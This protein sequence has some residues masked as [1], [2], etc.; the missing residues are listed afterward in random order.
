MNER[1]ILREGKRDRYINK[2]RERQRYRQGKR[3][4]YIDKKKETE[5]GR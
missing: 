2:D 5:M 3:D 1:Q 4:I